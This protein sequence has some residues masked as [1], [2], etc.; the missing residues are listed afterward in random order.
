[1]DFLHGVVSISSSYAFDKTTECRKNDIKKILSFADFD[2]SNLVEV[3]TWLDE[4]ES[5][6]KSEKL[7]KKD[8]LLLVDDILSKKIF[9]N[10]VFTD[11]DCEFETMLDMKKYIISKL[12]DH[13]QLL[14]A[15]SDLLRGSYKATNTEQLLLEF[16]GCCNAIGIA[17]VSLG[18]ETGLS[19]YILM[20]SLIGALPEE[21]RDK[22][23]ENL[24]ANIMPNINHLINFLDEMATLKLMPKRSAETGVRMQHNRG[25]REKYPLEKTFISEKKSGMQHNGGD[26]EITALKKESPVTCFCC[27]EKGHFKKK[28]RFRFVKCLLCQKRGHMMRVCQIFVQKDKRKINEDI[29][30]QN[31]RRKYTEDDSDNKS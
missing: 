27:G 23:V 15:V 25:D 6:A 3:N 2:I 4:V 18:I 16:K 12:F 14:R 1:M 28:C 11:N 9:G 30:T 8:V 19:E 31:K 5:F 22:Y 21:L 24:P 7:T 13:K 29:N 10:S 20:I 17:S 26:L